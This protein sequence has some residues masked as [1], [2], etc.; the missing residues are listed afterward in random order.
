LA[1]PGGELAKDLAGVR[2]DEFRR[3]ELILAEMFAG[4]TG[5]TV[6]TLLQDLRRARYFDPE[7]ARSYG[8]IDEVD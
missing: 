5:Q 7:E 2:A 6:E 1:G 8:L 3:M 4:D